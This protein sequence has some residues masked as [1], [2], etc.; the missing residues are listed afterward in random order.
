M[1]CAPSRQQAVHDT[2]LL[3]E[4]VQKLGLSVNK[5]KSCLVPMQTITYIGML[6]D[7]RA[8]S[9]TLSRGRADNI[10]QLLA[11]F[12]LGVSLQYSVTTT[13]RDVD[14]GHF[15]DTT[16]LA[17]PQATSAVCCFT[18]QDIVTA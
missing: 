8:M 1:L 7:S 18:P 13:S 12:Q 15:C 17:P 11:H 14:G 16:G 2:S 5:A 6:L 10:L 4:H 3:L 9:A